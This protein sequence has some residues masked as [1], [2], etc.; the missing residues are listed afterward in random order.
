MASRPPRSRMGRSSRQCWPRT[1]A[2]ACSLRLPAASQRPVQEQVGDLAPTSRGY[3]A[4]GRLATLTQGSRVWSFSYGGD[5][6]LASSTDL[7]GRSTA[8]AR[9][10]DERV[11]QQVLPDSQTVNL[12]YDPDG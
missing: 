2:G 9:D 5:G 6:F 4:R 12:T 3:D 11:T 10:P 1:L 7:L 8:F